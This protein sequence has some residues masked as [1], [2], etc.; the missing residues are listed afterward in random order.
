MIEVVLPAEDVFVVPRHTV[1]SDVPI[2]PWAG[3]EACGGTVYRAHL[4]QQSAV[5]AVL[6]DGALLG[7]KPGEFDFVCPFVV[8]GETLLPCKEQRVLGHP[9]CVVGPGRDVEIEGRVHEVRRVAIGAAGWRLFLEV[10]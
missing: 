1:R 4:N 9:W 6:T 8:G 7:L 10:R 3:A 2:V 5:S